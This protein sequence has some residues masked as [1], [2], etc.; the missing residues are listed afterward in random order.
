MSVNENARQEREGPL[1][2]PIAFRL[3]Q[4][5]REILEAFKRDDGYETL[6]PL[7]REAV[8]FYIVERIRGGRDA[9]RCDTPALNAG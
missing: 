8:N 6:T 9:V 7:L 1:S 3:L 2:E 4:S 5:R